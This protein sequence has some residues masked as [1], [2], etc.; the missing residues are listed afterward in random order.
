MWSVLITVT[1]RR[2]MAAWG[3]SWRLLKF[4]KITNSKAGGGMHLHKRS[5]AT[6]KMGLAARAE[7]TSRLASRPVGGADWVVPAIRALPSTGPA[8]CQHAGSSRDILGRFRVELSA[9]GV[10]IVGA[11]KSGAL[12]E[13][14]TAEGPWRLGNL[15]QKQ[16]S[17]CL[18]ASWRPPSM[19]VS[20]GS[21]LAATCP[22]FSINPPLKT[23]RTSTKRCST[24]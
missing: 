2:L 3:K 1:R 17:K 19:L 5:R 14:T 6:A 8:G 20:L 15:A 11:L 12:I 4:Q 21:A 7:S 18:A 24:S 16:C 13:K 22:G 23:A 10:D 9:Q